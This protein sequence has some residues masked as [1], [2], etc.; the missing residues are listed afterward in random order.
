MDYPAEVFDQVQLLFNATGFNDHQLHCVLRLESSLDAALLKKAVISS[1]EAIP[2]LGTRYI[3]G[4]KPYWTS[5]DPGR[6][7]EALV[8][9]RTEQAFEDIAASRVDEGRG[10]QIKVCYLDSNPFAIAI[11][12]NHMVCDAAG[13]KEY[14]YFLCNIYSEMLV[15][16]GFRPA[17]IVGNRS[18]RGVLGTIGLGAKLKSLLSQSRENNLA[19]THRFPLSQGGEVRPLILTRK[20]GKR[21]INALRAYCRERHATLN[22]AVLTSYYRC[23]FRRLSLSFGGEVNIP[24]MVDMRR[25][26]AQIKGFTALTNLSSTVITRLDHKSEEHFEDTLN[27]V[28]SMMDEKKASNIGLNAFI[29]LELLY[30]LLGNRKAN[31]LLKTSLKNP[32]ICM[33]N[34]GI[35]D[36][37]RLCFGD[38]H[39]YDA[40]LCGSIKY[41]PHFQLAMSSY[42]DEL[43][44]STNLYGNVTDRDR[45]ISFFNEIEEELF[46]WGRESGA[47]NG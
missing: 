14:L 5:I 1:I 32:L 22:D 27:R 12:M 21:R 46:I 18:I 40:F 47:G 41:K 33:T 19:G 43:T 36:R 31:G 16:P 39:P 38:L 26:L 10:P 30:R 8:I 35:L 3:N 6:F 20:I 44:L 2:I 37:N 25:Y 13:F 7:G 4:E 28:K 29:K 24:V 34:V 17:K 9:T 23:L 45:I 15:K 42:E 11:I